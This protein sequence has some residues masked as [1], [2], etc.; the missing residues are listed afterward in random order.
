MLDKTK[1]HNPSSPIGIVSDF[2]VAAGWVTVPIVLV[3][4]NMLIVQVSTLT[5]KY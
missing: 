5:I 3:V 1:M 2:F 4:H